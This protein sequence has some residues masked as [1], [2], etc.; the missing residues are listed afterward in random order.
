MRCLVVVRNL[1]QDRGYQQR[2]SAELERYLFAKDRQQILFL[3]TVNRPSAPA[4]E[5]PSS[6]QSGSHQR[7]S[8]MWVEASVRDGLEDSP[9]EM[10]ASLSARQTN[11]DR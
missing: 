2:R 5:C 10:V 8:M 3:K 4:I 7:I 1:S 9:N 11:L 6:D